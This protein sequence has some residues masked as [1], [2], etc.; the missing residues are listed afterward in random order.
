MSIKSISESISLIVLRHYEHIFLILLSY[1]RDVVTILLVY[2]ANIH[3][4]NYTF[5][6]AQMQTLSKHT[7]TLEWSAHKKNGKNQ[8]QEPGWE[9][10]K[11]GFC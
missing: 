2:I 10:W 6:H 5:S 3:L 9:G 8:A 11:E 7:S 1:A 4:F